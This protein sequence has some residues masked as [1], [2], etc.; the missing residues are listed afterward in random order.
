MRTNILIGTSLLL[1]GLI[2]SCSGQKKEPQTIE[3]EIA[4][5]SGRQLQLPVEP[6]FLR[7]ALDTA[8]LAMEEKE[9]KILIYTDSS[10]CT[11]CKLQLPKWK[12]M[13][14]LTD[15]LLPGKVA[16]LFF[17]DNPRVGEI[18]HLLKQADLSY[19]VCI[20]RG[21]DL[22]RLNNFPPNPQFQTFLLDKQ[23]RVMA[24]GNPALSPAIRELYIQ[25]MTGKEEKAPARRLTTAEAEP[26][27]INLG[28]LQG[29][30]TRTARVKII[31]RGKEPLVL[32]E[33]TTDCGCTETVFSHEPLPA[34]KSTWVEVRFAP[35]DKG[36][37]S[38]TIRLYANISE[39]I[40]LTLRGEVAS[41]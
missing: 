19:P 18:R 32:L 10:G 5:W 22:H 11:S 16:Y 41:L 3:Q 13:L 14:A 2:T 35:T 1:A 34:G 12:E 21:H 31:N 33:A 24:V 25:R 29:K 7:Y 9:Y 26:T 4:K 40:L 23:N 6:V 36:T 27:F 8:S 39:P 17:F 15:S 37:F 38:K 20:D 28:L 30:D